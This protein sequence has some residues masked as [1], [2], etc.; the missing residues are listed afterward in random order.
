MCGGRRPGA[1][2][3]K[4]GEHRPQREHRTLCTY[5][6]VLVRLYEPVRIY[7]D[8]RYLTRPV[9]S[10]FLARA[11]HFVARFIVRYVSTLRRQSKDFAY[12]LLFTSQTLVRTVRRLL[13]LT[14]STV[15]TSRTVL[16]STYSCSVP[17]HGRYP[18]NTNDKVLKL[19]L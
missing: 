8:Y 19:Y 6:T 13:S 17:C 14:Y 18:R 2:E 5:C 9:G 12:L 3:K 7:T 15:R 4:K 16:K 11:P 10:Y 1:A